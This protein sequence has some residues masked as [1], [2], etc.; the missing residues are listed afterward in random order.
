M[1]GDRFRAPVGEGQMAGVAAGNVE[2]SKYM[3][4]SRKVVALRSKYCRGKA[5]EI[6]FFW[7]HLRYME[8]PGPGIESEPQL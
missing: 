8:V 1:A 2:T 5:E 3:E 6:F 7:L 4:T